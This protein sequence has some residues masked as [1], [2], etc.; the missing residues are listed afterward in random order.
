[1]ASLPEFEKYADQLRALNLLADKTR[2][3][4]TRIDFRYDQVPALPVRKLALRMNVRGDE[5]QQRRFLQT[6]LNA[7]PNLSVARLAFAKG[8][9]GIIQVEQKL[10]VNLYYRLRPKAAA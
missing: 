8:T 10:D 6:M 5:A 7:F 9:D 1:M 2:V 3:V 4:I